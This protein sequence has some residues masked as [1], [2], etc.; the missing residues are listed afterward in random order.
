MRWVRKGAPY[1][2]GP[3]SLGTESHKRMRDRQ[4]R[5]NQVSQVSQASF[6]VGEPVL[7]AFHGMILSWGSYQM[8]LFR[9]LFGIPGVVRR[10]ESSEIINVVFLTG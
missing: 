10:G 1:T 9:M 7:M 5:G 3:T 2:E 6:Y 4:Q 8:L